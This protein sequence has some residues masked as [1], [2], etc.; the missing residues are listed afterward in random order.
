MGL[1]PVQ[2]E[3]EWLQRGRERCWNSS[4]TFEALLHLDLFKEGRRP[5]LNYCILQRLLILV[6]ISRGEIKR[7]VHPG[8][9]QREVEEGVNL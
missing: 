8:L 7:A 3:G 1:H 4:L 2:V 5:A 9:V 6:I